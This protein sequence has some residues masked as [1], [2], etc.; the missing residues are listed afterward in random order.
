MN[1]ANPPF[2]FYYLAF[3]QQNFFLFSNNHGKPHL[4][5]KTVAFRLVVRVVGTRLSRTE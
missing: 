4:V 5:A 3:F 1:D 2:Q